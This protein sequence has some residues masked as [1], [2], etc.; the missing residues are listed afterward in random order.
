MVKRA[1][2]NNWHVGETPED[3]EVAFELFKTYYAQHDWV[4]SRLYEGVLET[5]QTLKNDGFKLACITNKTSPFTNP[6]METAGLAP[7]FNF[8]A[9]GDTFVEMK[10]NPLPLLETAKRFDV[11]PE[12][13][14][15]IG[16]SINDITAGK[17]ADFKTIAVSYGYAGQHTMAD[18][19]ADYTV[20][21]MPEIVALI[22]S[23]HN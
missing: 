15:M 2:L 16:D 8:I 3:F 11:L 5:L 21:T 12:K 9:S 4:H 18:L 13:A 6:L 14:W 1:L 23:H 22:S 7:Y 20:N 10:P 17:K 19:N